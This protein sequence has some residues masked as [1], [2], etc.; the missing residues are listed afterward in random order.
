M[1]DM[2][3][4]P[5]NRRLWQRLEMAAEE[6]VARLLRTLPAPLR[7]KVRVLPIVFLPRP[8]AQMVREGTETDALGLF[9]G[10]PYGSE[11]SATVGP[12][13]VLFLLNLWD[14]AEHD[15]SAY[16]TQVR[17]TLLHEIGHYLGC[18]ED[19]LHDRDMD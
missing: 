18:D 4:R 7:A 5:V 8:T 17:R 13:I 15:A 12:E 6:E 14:E 1:D 3:D 11:D 10:A 19:A 2:H 9:A 16:R